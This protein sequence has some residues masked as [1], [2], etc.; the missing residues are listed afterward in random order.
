MSRDWNII[1]DSDEPAEEPPEEEDSR[2]NGERIRLIAR[3]RRAADRA[4]LWRQ[5]VIALLILTAL[6]VI[7]R[8]ISWLS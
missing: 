5:G 3:E 8:M 1:D 7:V 4:K 2:L 6:I